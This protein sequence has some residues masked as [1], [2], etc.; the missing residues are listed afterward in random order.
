[1]KILILSDIHNDIEN[2]MKF[3]DE[4]RYVKFDVLVCPGDLTD[5]LTPKGFSKEE[6]GELIIEE[7][8]IFKK[9]ILAVPGNQ[10][11]E[12]IQLF[13][14]E[15]INLHGKGKIVGDYGFYGFG[16][17]K[18]P[19]QTS[20][21]PTEEEIKNGL[22]RAFEEI[23]KARKK[24]QVTHAPPA[25]TKIDK[26][27]TGAHV[28]SEAVR[29]FIEEKQPLLAISAHVHEARGVDEIGRTK[30]INSGRFPEGY[31]GL[32]EINE[33]VEKMEVINLI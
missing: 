16:G 3:L 11:K 14:K 1:M 32:I 17:A 8:K 30:L 9:N 4:L 29:K 7:F 10:D 22:E 26:I 20:L 18:T 33:K 27:F 6:I 23:K 19:F 28:G 25:R 15:G 13:E 24:I 21:E 2:L 5:T 12:L 31:Y